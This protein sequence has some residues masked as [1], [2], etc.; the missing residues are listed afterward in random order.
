MTKLQKQLFELRDE[1]Y[2]AFQSK[3][4]PGIDPKLF[5][6]VKVP[7]LRK[8]AKEYTKDAECKKFLNS[9]PHKYY[10]ENMLHGLILS[11]MKDYEETLS[12]VNAFLPYID[13]WAVCDIMSP[14]CFKKNKGSLINEIKKW[15]KSKK[16]YT[17]RFGI[18]MLMSHFLDDDF[19]S[20]YLKIPAAVKSEE[21]YV[22]M[23]IAWFFAT[24]LAKQWDP[25]ILYIK[26]NKLDVWTHNKTIQ[27]ASE[28]FRITPQQKEF[29]LSMKR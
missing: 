22:N 21:Y 18:E 17:C 29:L 10:D 3:L 4:T 16:V 11:E 6:G 28:S 5:I 27:K 15:A 2:A 23:M 13:N 20:E 9:L 19:K 7:V 12:Y 1:N 24:A 8:F 26:N 14:K 25:A